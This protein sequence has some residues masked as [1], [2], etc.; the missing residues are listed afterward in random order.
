MGRYD[1]DKGDG[2]KTDTAM[3]GEGRRRQEEGAESGEHIT[4]I[5]LDTP[6]YSL[7]DLCPA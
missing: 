6:R 4:K 3:G 1:K 2:M 5:N 7:W